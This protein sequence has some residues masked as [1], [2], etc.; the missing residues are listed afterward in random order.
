LNYVLLL[1]DRLNANLN[2][3]LKSR[4]QPVNSLDHQTV[5]VGQ[6]GILSD[7]CEGGKRK[8]WQSTC[9]R[10]HSIHN[11]STG[12]KNPKF[13]AIRHATPCIRTGRMMPRPLASI[14]SSRKMN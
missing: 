8:E 1:E 7:W 14:K 3:P 11:F 12:R 5:T 6:R 2:W 4:A 10:S 9:P 13:I